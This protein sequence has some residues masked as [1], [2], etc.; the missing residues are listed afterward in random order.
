M[1]KF[2]AAG[3]AVV[4]LSGSLGFATTEAVAA[5]QGAKVVRVAQGAVPS[6]VKVQETTV[7]AALLTSS[8]PWVDYDKVVTC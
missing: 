5:P 3:V 8:Q 4:A 6:C 1:R 7:D 2:A